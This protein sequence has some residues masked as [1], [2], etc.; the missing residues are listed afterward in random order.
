M[1]ETACVANGIIYRIFSD[2]LF[3]TASFSSQV[4]RFLQ[5]P[6]HTVDHTTSKAKLIPVQTRQFLYFLTT[7]AIIHIET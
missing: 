5:T 6:V 2:P 1:I 7:R 3:F 4:Q